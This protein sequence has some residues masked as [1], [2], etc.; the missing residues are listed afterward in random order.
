MIEQNNSETASIQKLLEISE[1][2]LYYY[3]TVNDG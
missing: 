3:T 2:I 1:I